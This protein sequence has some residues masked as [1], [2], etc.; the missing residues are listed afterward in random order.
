[1]FALSVTL[2]LRVTKIVETF[3]SLKKFKTYSM[4]RHIFTLRKFFQFKELIY[5]IHIK[6]D[7]IFIQ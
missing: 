6:Y 5:I 1:M 3:R 7:A 4:K 2:F